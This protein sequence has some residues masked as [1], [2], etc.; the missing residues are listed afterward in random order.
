MTPLSVTIQSA[1]P[2]LSAQAT[3]DTLPTPNTASRAERRGEARGGLWWNRSTG[4]QE[5]YCTEP[6]EVRYAK[7]KEVPEIKTLE[8]DAPTV[9]CKLK[10]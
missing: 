9:A 1:L 4:M 5:V 8:V 3:T 10:V 6:E 2:A 7:R